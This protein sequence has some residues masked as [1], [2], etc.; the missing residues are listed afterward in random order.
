MESKERETKLRED[1]KGLHS[2][3]TANNQVEVVAE[4]ILPAMMTYLSSDTFQ[5]PV[6]AFFAKHVH[7]F[8]F[9][10]DS[11]SLDSIEWDHEH[12]TVYDNYLSLVDSLLEDFACKQRVTTAFIYSCCRDTGIQIRIM[13]LC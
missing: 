7:L 1:A 3:V 9:C 11:K 12:M 6:H 13:R 5:L 10:A 2:L 8:A 4:N